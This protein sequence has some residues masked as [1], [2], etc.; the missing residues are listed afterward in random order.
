VKSR[1]MRGMNHHFPLVQLLAAM[2]LSWFMVFW[3]NPC[4]ARGDLA[5]VA[6][7]HDSS[8]ILNFCMWLIFACRTG[9]TISTKTLYQ[10]SSSGI[11]LLASS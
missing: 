8:A 7:N 6:T 10:S 5:E 1:S 11:N 4:P 3:H 9:V 2:Q